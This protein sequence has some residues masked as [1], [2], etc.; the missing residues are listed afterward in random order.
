MVFRRPPTLIIELM[1]S[2]QVTVSAGVPTI[3]TTLLASMQGIGRKP[4]GLTDMLCGGSAPAEA[5]MRA[6]EQD[7][8]VN[9]VQG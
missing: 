6:Y 2:E 7:F 1:D 8:R 4:A 3:V 5:L 9:F